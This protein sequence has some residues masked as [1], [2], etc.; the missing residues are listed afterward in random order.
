MASI[1]GVTAKI[2]IPGQRGSTPKI[3]APAND[4]VTIKPKRAPRKPKGQKAGAGQQGKKHRSD[5]EIS[6]EEYGSGFGGWARQFFADLFD[7][8]L[9]LPDSGSLG[10]TGEALAGK[11]R[12]AANMGRPAPQFNVTAQTAKRYNNPTLQVI[13]NQIADIIDSMSAINSELKNQLNLSRYNYNQNLQ[14]QRE[15]ILES[16]GAQALLA[17]NDNAATSNLGSSAL[18]QAI[19]RVTD[20]LVDLTEQLEDMDL[21]G[22]GGAPNIDTDVDG[23]S[24][25]KRSWRSR[26]KRWLARN[27]GRLRRGARFLRRGASAAVAFGSKALKIGKGGLI[28]AATAIGGGLVADYLGRETRLGAL[29]A[30]ASKAGEYA[31]YGSLAGGL[32]GAGIGALFGGAGALPGAMIG[33]RIGAIGGALLGGGMGLVENFGALTGQGQQIPQLPVNNAAI[34]ATIRNRESSGDYRTPHPKGM[35]GTASGAYAF[36]DDT[37]RSLTAKYGIGTEYSRAY[38]APPPIQDA[39]ADRY[40]SEILAEAGGDVSK[41]PLKW[42]TGNINGQMSPEALRNNKGLTAQA[43]QAAWMA[44]YGRT[45]GSPGSW[46][47]PPGASTPPPAAS[48]GGK[49]GKVTGGTTD[50]KQTLQSAPTGTQ[51][52]KK[53]VNGQQPSFLLKWNDGTFRAKARGGEYVTVGV[54]DATTFFKSE[55]LNKTNDPNWMPKTQQAKPVQAAPAAQAPAP[56]KVSPAAAASQAVQKNIPKNSGATLESGSRDAAN[57]SSAPNVN[58]MVDPGATNP[59]PAMGM[60]RGGPTKVHGMDVLDNPKSNILDDVMH[61]VKYIGGV[62]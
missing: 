35:G 46:T 31:G 17:A 22:R 40:V 19:K 28:G 33:S 6:I 21:S 1:K 54:D 3:N 32:L 13:S 25:K 7:I 48:N 41:V 5:R 12:G 42:Y 9:K 60:S 56:P 52:F 36:T 38:L 47:P 39:V 15:N 45:L 18:V 57:M 27:R 59:P 61:K 37:W 2:K 8:D 50:V 34:L 20:Q 10:L 23:P 53:G 43:Y 4:V 55:G 49:A 24:K 30:T 14:V 16:G 58:V 26:L 62:R 11:A 44:D 29:A 51:W